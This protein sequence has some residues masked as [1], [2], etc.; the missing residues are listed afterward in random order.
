MT[1]PA[2]GSATF[3]LN[4]TVAAGLLGGT[5]SNTATVAAP[6]GTTDPTLGNNSATDSDTI[7]IPLPALGLLDN[8]NRANANTLNNGTNWSQTTLLGFAAIRVNANQAQV[9]LLPGSAYWNGPGNVFGARQG[10]AF[11]FVQSGGN[12]SAPQAGSSLIL[13]ASG[14]TAT[15]PSNFIS[16]AYQG[17]SVTV[18]TTVPGPGGTVQ[19]ATFTASFV[20]G[21]TLSATAYADGTVNVYKTTGVTT[22]EVGSV[23]IAGPGF[24]TGTGRIGM[25]L[26]FSA[27]VDNFSGQ[28]V[29]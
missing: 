5:L 19:R 25:T 21:D 28:T 26:P 24:W 1:L 3:T 13:K 18:S 6:A 14:G 7:A 15:A 17:G 22:T 8:F 12:P 29:P 27:R 16:V 4:G 10:A 11:T 9:P 23:T 2:G 20:A